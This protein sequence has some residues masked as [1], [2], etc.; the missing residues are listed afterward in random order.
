MVGLEFGSWWGAVAG[1]GL[2][3]L[4]I[5]YDKVVAPHVVEPVR[6]EF[7]FQFNLG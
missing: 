7:N 5:G 1:V 2:G 3:A 4:E 6:Q